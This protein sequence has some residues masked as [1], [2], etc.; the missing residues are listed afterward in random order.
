MGLMNNVN[1]Q[2]Q[3]WGK[4]FKI[5]QASILGIAIYEFNIKSV[6]FSL[7]QFYNTLELKQNIG[8]LDAVPNMKTW[9]RNIIFVI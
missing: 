3:L 5:K 9:L 4:L 8:I 2:A 1:L 6:L 7:L